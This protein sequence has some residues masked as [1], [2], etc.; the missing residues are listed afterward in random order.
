MQQKGKMTKEAMTQEIQKAIGPVVNGIKARLVPQ[1]LMRRALP[2]GAISAGDAMP[3]PPAEPGPSVSREELRVRVDHIMVAFLEDIEKGTESWRA[4]AQAQIPASELQRL[5]EFSFDIVAQYAMQHGSQ[6]LVRQVMDKLQAMGTVT[7]QQAEMLLTTYGI[8]SAPPAETDHHNQA[9]S[10]PVEGD[11]DGGDL[12]DDRGEGEGGEEEALMGEEAALVPQVDVQE[13][14]GTTPI[15]PPVMR[16][17][18]KRR[19]KKNE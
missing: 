5:G 8:A 14:V 1:S 6:E 7:P 16:A 4:V 9:A 10:A 2:P 19:P 17:T 13:R 12:D 3:T 18:V 15:P 11:D